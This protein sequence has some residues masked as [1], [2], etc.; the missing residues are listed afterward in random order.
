MMK[1]RIEE[2]IDGISFLKYVLGIILTF[3]LQH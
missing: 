1:V 2:N 3:S